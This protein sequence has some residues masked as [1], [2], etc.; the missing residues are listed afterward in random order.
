PKEGG[1]QERAGAVPGRHARH[2]APAVRQRY[3]N[4]GPGSRSHPTV[5]TWSGER[6]TGGGQWLVGAAEQRQIRAQT[7]RQPVDRLLLRRRGRATAW[8]WRGCGRLRGGKKLGDVSASAL[9]R[10]GEGAKPRKEVPQRARREH[11]QDEACHDREV[12]L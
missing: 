9:E 11:D 10:G 2:Q 7:L 12:D 5:A 3:R 6:P 4:R 8:W 1:E